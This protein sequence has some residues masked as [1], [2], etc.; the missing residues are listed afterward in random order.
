MIRRIKREI[1]R[2]PRGGKRHRFLLVAGVAV[3]SIGVF[4]L[5]SS[6]EQGARLLGLAQ[7]GVG[8]GMVMAGA[9]E[10]L[11]DDEAA[12]AVP[13]RIGALVVALSSIALAVYSLLTSLLTG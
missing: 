3:L 2:E 6:S 9:S 4:F 12:L 5:F 11:R 10:F 7:S 8:L 13:L 1:S